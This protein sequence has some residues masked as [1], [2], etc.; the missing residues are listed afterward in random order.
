M[1][2]RQA[3]V[4]DARP[5]AQIHVASWQAAYRGQLPDAVLDNLD[6]EKRATF[7]QT[8]LSSRPLATLVAESDEE[9]IGFCDLIPSRDQDANPRLTAEIAAIYVLPNHW[10]HGA[11]RALCRRALEVVRR[12]HFTA[13]TLWVL[14]SNSTAQKFYRTM[15]FHPDGATKSES[16]GGQE[17]QEVRFRITV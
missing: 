3:T 1:Q 17:L 14:A 10:R 6:V 16:F 13:I 4:S 5:I 8:H 15:G 9:I 12:E 2:I 7:W 11:G